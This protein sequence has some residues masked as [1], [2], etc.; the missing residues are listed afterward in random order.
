MS[1]EQARIKAIRAHYQKSGPTLASGDA[2]ES[3][4]RDEYLSLLSTIRA[5]KKEREL[6]K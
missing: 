2:Q 4:P 6:R 5:S 3:V 1:K